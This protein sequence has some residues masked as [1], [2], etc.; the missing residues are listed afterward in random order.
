M[1]RHATELAK[2]D[3]ARE[4]HVAALNAGARFPR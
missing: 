4:I 1:N 2:L 3:R